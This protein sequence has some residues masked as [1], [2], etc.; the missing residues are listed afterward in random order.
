MPT[1]KINKKLLNKLT[2]TGQKG[3]KREIKEIVK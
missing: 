2:K 3:I 1:L